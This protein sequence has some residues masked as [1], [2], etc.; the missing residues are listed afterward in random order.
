MKRIQDTP[1]YIIVKRATDSQ[2]RKDMLSV[3]AYAALFMACSIGFMY[4]LAFTL[5]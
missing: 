1:E 2:L 3:V 4:G 5:F